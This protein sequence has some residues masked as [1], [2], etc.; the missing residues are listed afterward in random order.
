[1][2][3]GRILWKED[4]SV[5]ITPKESTTGN[6]E[7]FILGGTMLDIFNE[8]NIKEYRSLP[9]W[10]WNDK[11]DPDELTK[12]IEWMHEQGFGGFFM[13]ARGGLKTQYLGK[14]W[15]ECICRCVQKSKELHLQ[16]WAYDE[17]GW[18]S[19]FAGGKLLAREEDRDRYLT[20][21][22]GN[23]DEKALVS[24]R[25][26]PETLER[27]N[28]GEDGQYL[29]IY[30][31]VSIS[32]AD[33]LNGVVVDKFIHCTHEKYKRELGDDWRYLQG[34]FTDEPQYF[35]QKHPYTIVLKDYFKNEYGE[36][37]F[38]SLGLLF[39]E[40][41]GYRAFRYKYWK[42]M[43]TL[44]LKNF[45][46]RIYTWCEK[47]GVRLT[48]HYI[49]ES[50][51]ISQMTCCGGIMPFYEFEHIPGID[52]LKR[53]IDTPVAAKQVSSVARQLGKKQVITESFAMCGWAVTPAEL[54]AI[55]E[56]QYVNGVNLLC[57]HLLPYSE[58]G[59]RKRD[60]PAH[61]SWINPW[62]A[63][64]YR[65]FNDYFARLGYLLAESEEIVDIAVFVPLRSMYFDYKREEYFK[66][67]P[68][69]ASY[70]GLIKKLSSMNIQYHLLDETILAKYGRADGEW[71]RVGKCAYKYIIFPKT[72]TM[73]KNSKKLFDEFY[74]SGG[75][76]LFTDGVPVYLEGE[77]CEYALKS[78]I[79]LEEI[80]QAQPYHVTD[81]SGA[82]QSAYH[83]YKGRPFLFA[84]NTDV[85]HA[86]AATFTGGFHSFNCLDLETNSYSQKGKRLEFAPG[87]S[88][89][90]FLS[91]RETISVLEPVREKVCLQPPFTVKNVSQNYL[92]LDKARYSVD[93]STYS[94]RL[95][96]MGI[97]NEL[98]GCQYRGD[99]WLKYE[100][101]IKDIPPEIHLLAEVPN[102]YVCRVNGKSI[103]FD[104]TAAFEKRIVSSNI[105]PH[106]V[107]GNNE[108]VIK[109]HFKQKNRIYEILTD[110]NVTESL[111]NCLTFDMTIE[112]CYLQGD[113]GVFSEKGFAPGKEK[114]VLIA[115]DDFYIGEKKT[116]LTDL[117][118]EGYPF[119]AGNITLEKEFYCNG[120][121][122]ILDLSGRYH[123]CELKINGK[124]VA[125]SYF[126]GAADIS[127][128]VIK[129]KNRA[130]ITLFSSNRNLLG[131]HH[132][133]P[134]EEPFDVTPR[135]FELPN[136]W[137][138]GRSS[139]ERDNYTFVK[140]GL[141]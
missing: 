113:F 44:M 121:P 110:K 10:S 112:S 71:L 104:A 63:Y 67:T 16:A 2:Y 24:Y 116:K 140:F 23:F 114:N 21:S 79:T 105:T 102:K 124:E 3:R 25:I 31:H 40:K 100:F 96:C 81:I 51:L 90:L 129:G 134:S 64:N 75:K 138:N 49:E 66:K 48:G 39:I 56:A 72:L 29:N 97:F 42:A 35:R 136:S 9:F 19:G 82:I 137:Q 83:I 6:F 36:D 11:L 123:L 80:L 5:R 119:F 127:D 85:H 13:H 69:D 88:Y 77:E 120:E 20:Y 57:Q 115:E 78:N 54:K 14:E 99:I 95:S 73:D 15:F 59:Q 45:S 1:M 131:P 87:Q 92:T 103:R 98:L 118:S 132:Y 52:K 55:A 37:I 68:I 91:D 28:V 12:Q 46:E 101:K 53:S 84:V 125:K 89:V 122:S 47:N 108:I 7:K 50:L 32:T 130:E 93:G 111:K 65:P 76:I 128:Y 135:T 60:Y 43:Q 107:Q 26:Q 62:V 86:G 133:L 117:V 109:F 27:A 33:I 30:E 74:E 139:K 126:G 141:F 8:A 41:K 106:L 94:E 58:S 4:G 18:P 34:F 70:E 38:D 22:I 17:N 61:Y